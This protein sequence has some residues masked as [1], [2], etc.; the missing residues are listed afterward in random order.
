[1]EGEEDVEDLPEGVEREKPEEEDKDK[2]KK[3]EE[4]GDTISKILG[5]PRK[6][7]IT[8]KLI[9]EMDKEKKKALIEVDR[10]LI[11]KL[12]PHQVDGELKFFYFVSESNSLWFIP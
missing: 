6:V 12:K 3:K 10:T 7:P 8:T 5:S 9:L 11:R 4:T 1:M 2:K